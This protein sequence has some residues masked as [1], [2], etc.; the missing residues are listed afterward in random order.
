MTIEAASTSAGRLASVLTS[1]RVK[2]RMSRMKSLA[3]PSA[4]AAGPA[5]GTVSAERRPGGT[6]LLV[7]GWFSLHAH[8][9]EYGWKLL[10]VFSDGERML[11][12]VVTIVRIGRI[13]ALE[14]ERSLG[15]RN[16]GAVFAVRPFVV[17]ARARG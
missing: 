11:T 6:R 1:R 4:G 10:I 7:I 9:R 8:N 13:P 2:P 5:T 15:G 16:R 3:C 17:Y 14:T 12:G